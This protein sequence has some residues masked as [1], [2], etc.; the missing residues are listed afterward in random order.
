MCCFSAKLA[1][2]R[3]KS[4]DWLAWNQDNVSEWG[5]MSIAELALNNNHSLKLKQI[6]DFV[7][8][9]KKIRCYGQETFEHEFVFILEKKKTNQNT[10]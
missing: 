7:I 9:V 3:R 8:Q 1:T 6:I 2:L 5:D 4:K 10:I